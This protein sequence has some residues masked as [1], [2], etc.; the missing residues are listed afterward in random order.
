M[1]L[2]PCPALVCGPC[3]CF[4][5]ATAAFACGAFLGA[6]ALWLVPCRRTVAAVAAVAPTTTATPTTATATTSSSATT[7]TTKAATMSGSGDVVGVLRSRLDKVERRAADAERR[8]D[9]EAEKAV[10]ARLG[11]LQSE[12]QLNLLR[13]NL[14]DLSRGPI[15]ISPSG[16]CF[17]KDPNC[18]HLRGSRAITKRRACS[19][20]AGHMV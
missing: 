6:V 19:Y 2:I 12:E 14:K 7:A 4:A 17:H 13:T 15:W 10:E 5:L 18:G 11:L 9:E 3:G 20:C 16:E 1:V 8:A